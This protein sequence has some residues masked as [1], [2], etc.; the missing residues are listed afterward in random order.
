M[1]IDKILKAVPAIII[2]TIDI[3]IK[4]GDIQKLKTWLNDL[5]IEILRREQNKE[6]TYNLYCEK[7]YLEVIL[8]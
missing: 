6:N 5:N 1:S 2:E 3:L 8:K 7:T 4:S